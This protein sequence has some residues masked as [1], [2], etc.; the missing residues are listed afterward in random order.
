MEHYMKIA[1]LKK[2]DLKDLGEDFSATNDKGKKIGF[3]NYYME[4]DHKPFYGV[5]GEFHFSRCDAKRWEDELVKM[6]LGG[7]TVISTYVFWNHHEEEEGVFEFSGNK[8][9]RA[10]I[11]LCK[12]HSL[13]VIL[14]IGPF[15]HGEVRNGGMPDWLYGKPFEVRQLNEGFLT[16]TKRLYIKIAEQVKGLFFS[17]NGP[18]IG[19]QLDNEYMHSSAPWESTTG[20][21]N[22]WVPTGKDGKAYM[23]KLKEIAEECGIN[24]V[25]YTC[26]GWG[27]A[28]TPDNMLPLWGGYAF[29][30]WLFYSHHGKHPSTEEYVYQEFH[31]NEVPCV[32]DFQPSY[33]PEERPYACCEMGGG[34]F[35]SYNYRFVLPF[36]SV[37]AMANIKMASGCNFLGYYM[38][39]GGT[40]PLGKHGTFMNESQAPKRSYDFQAPLGEFGQIRESYGRLK[41]IHYFAETFQ[42]QLCSLVTV[43]PQ[44]ASTIEPNDLTTLRYAV[45]TD[46]KRGFLF[47]NNYQDHE[48]MTKKSREQI[49]LE[50]E[51]EKVVFP[52]IDIAADENCIL[53]FHMEL[54]G[55]DLITATAQPVTFVMTKKGVLYV[56]MRPE[57]MQ[58]EFQFSKDAKINGT[59]SNRFV[60]D[61]NRDAEVFFVEEGE[62][63]I[64]ILCVS[65]EVSNNMYRLEGKG[66][67][68]TD[69]ALLADEEGIQIESRKHFNQI[70]TYPSDLLENSAYVTRIETDD[71]FVLGCY[72]SEC[73]KVTIEPELKQVGESRYTVQLPIGLKKDI[74]DL[75]LKIEYAG[76]IG[77]AFINGQLIHDNFCNGAAWEI[78]VGTYLEQ[79]ENEPITIYIT[80]LKEG[81]NVNVESAMA[82]R[83]EEVEFMI[84]AISSI[85]AEPVYELRVM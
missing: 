13:D 3:T 36:K 45:R 85:C 58:A 23:L 4:K 60:M 34:M 14:R 55:I 21:S 61:E 79:L 1:G 59:D 53:P 82:A 12:K 28:A 19:V 33:K 63:Q 16:Y 64:Q 76:D 30:P 47:I 43:L 62:Q 75:I 66:V 20:I 5:S 9:L 6:K 74:K 57:G 37:D 18:I 41:T 7:I 81:V 44:G 50:L 68:F 32:H 83:I 46:G 42:E 51:T 22:E 40:N 56:F 69:A 26:T 77:Q 54:Q 49:T 52:P 8:D 11:K 72:K 73:R 70:T 29:R 15:A 71:D 24:P 84:G 17:D 65:R 35:S 67:L 39:H 78:S 27:G 31:N 10:F 48:E 38:Y 80:P 25:F 2:K